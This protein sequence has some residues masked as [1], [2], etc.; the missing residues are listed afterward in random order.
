MTISR[1]DTSDVK[2]PFISGLLSYPK[3]LSNV[4]VVNVFFSMVGI[5]FEAFKSSRGMLILSLC[6]V[7]QK[8]SL[9]FKLLEGTLRVVVV[10][11]VSFVH[12]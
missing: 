11:L 5:V 12:S 9:T 3:I 10:R 8:L 1:I 6:I 7:P 2:R 4:D